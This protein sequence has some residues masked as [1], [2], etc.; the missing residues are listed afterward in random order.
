MILRAHCL[1]YYPAMSRIVGSLAFLLIVP[2]LAAAA[3]P[4]AAP[5]TN[6]IEVVTQ[7]S[8]A[9]TPDRRGLRRRGPLTSSA[10]RTHLIEFWLV[11]PYV[12]VSP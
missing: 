4:A 5:R 2:A 11:I 1:R 3:E 6:T 10:H 9:V 8:V 7:R 12:Y